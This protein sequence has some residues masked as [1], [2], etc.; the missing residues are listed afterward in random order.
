MSNFGPSAQLE[1]SVGDIH[2]LYQ[3][4]FLTDIKREV[5][6]AQQE[7]KTCKQEQNNA[8]FEY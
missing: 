4:L 6:V 2:S 8:N 1:S 3:D 5:E 7:L